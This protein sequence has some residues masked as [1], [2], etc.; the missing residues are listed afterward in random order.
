MIV[1]VIPLYILDNPFRWI[2]MFRFSLR[3]TLLAV[4]GLC[5]AFACIAKYIDFKLAQSTLL[6]KIESLSGF[7]TEVDYFGSPITVRFDGAIGTPDTRK[8]NDSDGKFLATLKNV[9]GI[10]LSHTAV[11]DQILPH[12]TDLKNL[13]WVSLEQTNTTWAALKELELKLPNCIVYH[14]KNPM[15]RFGLRKTELAELNFYA[16]RETIVATQIFV[17][18][19]NGEWP[20]SWDDLERHAPTHFNLNCAKGL[21]VVD[22]DADVHQLSKQTWK[23]F[24]GIRPPQPC[25]TYY[26]SELEYLIAMLPREIEE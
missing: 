5:L 19:T 12:L 6:S 25:C 13:D 15:W 1:A 16:M 21:V 18:E 26:D 11:T 24:S 9:R 10:S 7:A 3:N 8:I 23:T 4:A 17:R 14:D 2:S 20:T 22:F